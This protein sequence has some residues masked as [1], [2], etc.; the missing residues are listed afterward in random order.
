MITMG[1]S[2]YVEDGLEGVMYF[3]LS[4]DDV[5]VLFV[6][7]RLEYIEVVKG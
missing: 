7:Y 3:E 2:F 1:I 6:V 5:M 4:N